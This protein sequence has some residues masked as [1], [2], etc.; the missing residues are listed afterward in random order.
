ME[1]RHKA[2]LKQRFPRI[3]SNK[4]I[5]ILNI[6]DEFEYMDPELITILKNKMSAFL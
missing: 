5:V 2:I 3:L 1:N 4:K 6:P